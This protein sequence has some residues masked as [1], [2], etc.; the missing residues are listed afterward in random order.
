MV[1]DVAGDDGFLSASVGET[2]KVIGSVVAMSVDVYGNTD[3][4]ILANRSC[5]AEDVEEGWVKLSVCALPVDISHHLTG[6]R[7]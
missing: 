6:V 4:V 1:E 5:G 7:V 3:E 2:V